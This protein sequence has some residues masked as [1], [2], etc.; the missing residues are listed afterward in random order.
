MPVS[1]RYE[2]TAVDDAL[3]DVTL[4]SKRPFA[5]CLL[6]TK[7]SALY[8]YIQTR[9][10]A[11]GELRGEERGEERREERRGEERRGRG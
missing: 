10:E 6:M 9:R 5:D 7:T 11:R 2:M 8:I 3:W 1:T 4:S